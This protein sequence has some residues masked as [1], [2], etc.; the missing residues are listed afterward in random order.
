MDKK[1]ELVLEKARVILVGFEKEKDKYNVAK[2][3]AKELASSFEEAAELADKVPVE[4]IQPL[5]IE[6]AKNLA[7]R[8]RDSGA[9]IEVVPLSRELGGG[10][11][12][13]RHPH[14]LAMAKCKV[15]GKLLCNLCL[16][17]SKGKLFCREHFVKY[18][19]FRWVKYSGVSITIV[20]MVLVWLLFNDSITRYFRRIMPVSSQRVA[21]VVFAVNPDSDMSEFYNELM[22]S[23]TG[24]DYIPGDKHA[25]SQLDSWFQLRYQEISHNDSDE[26]I[27]DF[28]VYGLFNAPDPPPTLGLKGQSDQKMKTYLK[29]I[30]AENNFTLSAYDMYLFLYLVDESP[31]DMDYVEKM[32]VYDG[33]FGLVVYPLKQVWSNDYYVMMTAHYLAKMMGAESKIDDKGFPVFPEGYGNPVKDPLFPQLEAELMGGYIPTKKF[34]IERVKSLDEVVIGA[35]FELGWISKSY[36]NK[37]YSDNK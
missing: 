32:G 7:D 34:T 20:L 31:V 30:A 37:A 2:S 8:I 17:E 36:M 1:E 25:I 29:N 11:T 23:G 24:G 12:C 10:R 16:I 27:L 15:C 35:A 21:I 14:K 5:P 28:D 13:Y 19:F 22:R 4:L 6:A 26:N 9:I 3:L 18:K 33:K